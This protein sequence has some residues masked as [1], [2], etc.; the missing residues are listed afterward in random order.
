MAST[1]GPLPPLPAPQ[2][3]LVDR[4][5]GLTSQTWYLYLKRLDEHVREIEKR[6]DAGGL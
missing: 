5:T 2:G 3:P 1:L 4:R 6:L